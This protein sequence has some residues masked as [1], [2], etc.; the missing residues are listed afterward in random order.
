MVKWWTK[1]QLEWRNVEYWP[2]SQ[3]DTG[4]GDWGDLFSSGKDGLYIFIMSLSWWVHTLDPGADPKVYKAISNVSWVMEHIITSLS[5]DAIVSNSS[6]PATPS[7]PA[8]CRKSF[9][10]G[11][12][13]K[14]R[15]N[16]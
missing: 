14:H 16:A 15:K 4:T 5:A 13:T 3:D 2:F 12:P 11:P 9:K 7:P 6:P 1:A 10:V 8:K